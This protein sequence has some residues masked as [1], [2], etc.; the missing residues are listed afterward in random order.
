MK[1]FEV[2]G[3]M[4][5]VPMG[6]GLEYMVNDEIALVGGMRSGPSRS[7]LTRVKY[8]IY[9]MIGQEGPLTQE[10]QDERKVGFL[11]LFIEDGSGRIEGL[12]NIKL[13]TG[14]RKGGYGRKVIDSLLQTAKGPIRIYDIKT[15][16]IPF[17]RKMGTK[18]Y[19]SSFERPV[20]NTKKASK[21]GLYGI[22]G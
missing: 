20:K 15:G 5:R 2:T 11:E 18:F 21:F 8:D 6:M 19:D 22:I 7:N 9:D 3:P 12:V 1:I 13:N 17:W 10:D 16:A 4:E 14:V